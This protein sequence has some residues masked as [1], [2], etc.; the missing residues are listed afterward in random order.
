[1]EHPVFLIIPSS[2]CFVVVVEVVVVVVVD[3]VISFCTVV[4]TVTVVALLS[5]E[6]EDCWVTS[7]LIR[8]LDFE[9]DL[10]A[11]YCTVLFDILN[12]S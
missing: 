9:S 11:I 5:F 10:A 12:E 2:T 1:M 8:E 3:V 7:W 6:L 4:L